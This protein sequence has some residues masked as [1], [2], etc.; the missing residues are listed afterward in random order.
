[1]KK[2]KKLFRSLLRSEQGLTILEFAI[3]API[4]LII[5]MGVFE[6][7]I[8]ITKNVIAENAIR[9]AGRDAILSASTSSA[10]AVSARVN[11]LTFDFI[12]DVIVSYDGSCIDL[13]KNCLC[14]AAFIDD[15]GSSAAQKA[16]LANQQCPSSQAG[17]TPS[18]PGA[19][20]LYKLN[21]RHE[22]FT[23]LGALLRLIGSSETGFSQGRLD[24]TSSTIVQNEPF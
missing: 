16:Q 2:A 1:M 12:D 8:I 17:V 22:F 13:T 5:I 23:P 20:V 18:T 24:F 9:G 6:I 15:A 3:I 11:E 4:F 19:L 21:Y 14:I 10:A 7:S